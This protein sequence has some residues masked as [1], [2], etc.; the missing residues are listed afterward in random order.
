[1][2]ILEDFGLLNPDG[3]ITD[4]FRARAIEIYSENSPSAQG[5]DLN[6]TERYGDWQAQLLDGTL[7]SSCKTLDIEAP[8]STIPVFDPSYVAAKLEIEEPPLD[9]A[10]IIASFAAPQAA[11]PALLNVKPDDIPEVVQKLPDLVEPPPALPTPVYPEAEVLPT[12]E[13]PSWGGDGVPN[14]PSQEGFNLAFISTLPAAQAQLDVITKDPTWWATFTPDKLFDTA[15]QVLEANV[16]PVTQPATSNTDDYNAEKKVVIQ[17]ASEAMAARTVATTVGATKLLKELG[18]IKGYLAVS[19]EEQPS[20]GE[21][22]KNNLYR[23]KSNEKN[24]VVLFPNRNMS[25]GDHLALET[26]YALADHMYQDKSYKKSPDEDPVTLEIGNI[27]GNAYL[28]PFGKKTG[29]KGVGW[30]INPWSPGGHGGMSFDMAYP[31]RDENGNW[32]SG[33]FTN[34]AGNEIQEFKPPS[35]YKCGPGGDAST[36]YYLKTQNQQTLPHDFPAMYEMGRWLYHEW[37]IGLIKQ[38]RL[39]P[40]PGLE[41]AAKLL[42]Y[43][44]ILVGNII[45]KKLNAW[46]IKNIGTNWNTA[47]VPL[48]NAVGWTCIRMFVPEDN[49]EDH[50]HAVGCRT[51]IETSLPPSEKIVYRVRPQ[52]DTDKGYR[53]KEVKKD[54]GS[55]KETVFV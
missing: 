54:F 40:W 8:V 11:I 47:H 55:G 5:Q 20:D 42:P 3:T 43:Q 18:K 32:M 31:M 38:G 52:Y 45:Y 21:A 6:D 51:T 37:F 22:L 17:L 9:L 13:Q 34:E 10:S 24:M 1:M 2:G 50:M 29:P 33:L 44:F 39:L 41:K 28:S 15:K 26:I 7:G 25:Y 30:R 27:T 12:T 53:G 14:Y 19:V 48:Y 4:A 35:P 46:G 16:E 23:L 49:H 36:P